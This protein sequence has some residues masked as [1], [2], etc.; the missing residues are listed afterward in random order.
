MNLTQMNFNPN[1]N[2]NQ[3]SKNNLKKSLYETQYRPLNTIRM[4]Q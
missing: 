3:A 1:F 4:F 2:T